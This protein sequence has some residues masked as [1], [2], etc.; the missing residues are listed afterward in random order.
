MLI[1]IICILNFNEIY[2]AIHG[3]QNWIIKK[4]FVHNYPLSPNNTHLNGNKMNIVKK[5]R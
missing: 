4:C 2:N 1:K 3:D 5:I